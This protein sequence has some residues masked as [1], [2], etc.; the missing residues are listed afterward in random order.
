MAYAN[1]PQYPY[2][3]VYFRKSSPPRED[4]EKD[5]RQAAADGMNCF[6]HWVM[7]GS[8]E[9]AP[10][11]YSWDDWDAQFDLA[12]KYGIKTII[13]ECLHSAPEWAFRRFAH[14]RYEDAAGL[15][16]GSRMRNSSATG[17]FSGLC[18]DNED[19]R[20]AAE[21]F[22][23]RLAD[24]YKDHPGLGGWDVWNETNLV[25]S[26]CV[27][28]HC[29]ASQ[30]KFR[31]W[32]RGKY[33]SLQ[34]V[35][36]AWRRYSFETWDDVRIP[37]RL[38]AYPDSIDYVDFNVENAVRLF[39]WRVD[40][41]RSVDSRSALT[42]HGVG[43]ATLH[44]RVFAADDA[45]QYARLLDG[46]GYGGGGG[47]TNDGF[48]TRWRNILIADTTRGGCE[49]KPFWAAERTAGPFWGFDQRFRR[50]PGEHDNW[51][52][53]EEKRIEAP[54]RVVVPVGDDIRANDMMAMS[55]GTKG[56]FSNRWRGLLDGPMFDAMGYYALDGSP[57]DRSE[58]AALVARWANSPAQAALW[59]SNP[60]VGD[61]GIVNAP[62]SQVYCQLLSGSTGYYI[63]TVRGLYTAL[64][65]D[66]I[67]PDIVWIEHIDRY[68]LLYLPCPILLKDRTI[69]RLIAWVEKGGKL[70]SDG[71]VAYF[72]E[73]GRAGPK[74]FHSGL[75]RLFGVEEKSTEFIPAWLS[76]NR[77]TFNLL[78]AKGL[79]AGYYLQSYTPK[80]GKA[81][82]W[83]ADGSV[84]AVENGCG[85]GRTL[86]IGTAPGCAYFERAYG[87]GRSLGG[88]IL[89]WAGKHQ[90]V[91]SSSDRLVVRMHDGA[92]GT[93][94]WVVNPHRQEI[95]ATVTLG[96]RWANRKVAGL[97]RGEAA[98]VRQDG[99]SIAVVVPQRDALVIELGK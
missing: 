9:V 29:P 11:K 53:A 79:V 75:D 63:N 92:G 64:M 82:G 36:E 90:H 1:L 85:K 43:D 71:A 62:E 26:G 21:E 76:Q 13:A 50:A 49:G 88:L 37:E 12:A 32:L 19:Y 56:L 30:E 84:A 70:V 4:W 68:D 44:R 2:G 16:L 58:A 59:K 40:T 65:D 10:G 24:R 48:D 72:H 8:I 87:E 25:S 17:G 89:G 20:K 77:P 47:M 93:F 78:G 45:W 23:R 60:V 99:A 80:G 18:L 94:L 51:F 74:H 5:Y 83:H 15:K 35:A 33:G 57:T 41:I 81:V 39:K 73:N 52:T 97:K 86:L 46:Y 22:L 42:A 95:S 98:S 31:E 67:Q 61:I 34:A 14:A 27:K 38:E 54:V 3:A 69:E 91:R 96:P 7:W 6:R 55:A 28:C 66:A